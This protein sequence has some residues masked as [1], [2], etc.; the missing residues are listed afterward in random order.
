MKWR[1]FVASGRPWF[2]ALPAVALAV[3][4][5]TELAGSIGALGAAPISALIGAVV[6]IVVARWLRLGPPAADLEATVDALP[7]R[8]RRFLR[9][10]TRLVATQAGR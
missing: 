1:A 3:L 10:S 6:Y 8:L 7:V 5:G 4:V 2:A 9:W